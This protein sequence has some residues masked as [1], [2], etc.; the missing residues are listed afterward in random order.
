MTLKVLTNRCNLS[1]LFLL[2]NGAKTG[3]NIR[4][5]V[6]RSLF[7]CSKFYRIK[8]PHPKMRF[9]W[10][11]C[12]ESNSG[13]NPALRASLRRVANV[14]VS[15][16]EQERQRKRL[17]L[18]PLFKLVFGHI[19]MPI[20]QKIP[21]IQSPESTG[22]YERRLGESAKLLRSVSERKVG[23]T[24]V[25]RLHACK[26]VLCKYFCL[27]YLGGQQASTASHVSQST[28]PSKPVTPDLHSYRSRNGDRD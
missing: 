24:E 22:L 27:R 16:E 18:R 5:D 7:L 1:L 6:N 4:D 9:S 20:S 15:V 17:Y 23:L 26:S 25:R 13:P 19:R 8:K 3:K 28:R 11:R 14:E 21:P 2:Q 10:W 12:G